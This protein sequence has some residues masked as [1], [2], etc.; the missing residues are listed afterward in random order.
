M[1]FWTL[2]CFESGF[3]ITT[4]RPILVSDSFIDIRKPQNIDDSISMASPS[5]SVAVDYPTT[6]SAII[7]QARLAVIANKVH[8]D[9]L[10]TRACTDV[11]H[12]VAIVEQRINNWRGSLPTF[13]FESDV[14]KWF[15]GP[16]QVVIWKESNIRIL[17]LL[18]G[19][20]HHTD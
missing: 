5:L 2:Y 16:R 20:R 13:F 15:L 19:E 10:S 17:L 9:V 3:S 4:G 7:A 14:P 6:C 1:L 11:N 12:Q 8:N 18:A